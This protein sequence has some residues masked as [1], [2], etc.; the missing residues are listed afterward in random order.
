MNML[1]IKLISA[2]KRYQTVYKLKKAHL[3]TT[4]RGRKK[5]I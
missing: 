3:K 4:K 1:Q 2:V 5:R